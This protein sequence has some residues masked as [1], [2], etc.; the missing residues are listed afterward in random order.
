MNKTQAS[1][2]NRAF[3]AFE[4]RIAELK[5]KL[6]PLNIGGRIKCHPFLCALLVLLIAV[7]PVL[8]LARTQRT[9]KKTP[10]TMTKQAALDSLNT[11]LSDSIYP[12]EMSQ[13]KGVGKGEI[14]AW[15]NR[16]KLSRARRNG[17]RRE[18]KPVLQGERVEAVLLSGVKLK[19]S[20]KATSVLIVGFYPDLQQKLGTA[21]FII[22]ED[23]DGNGGDEPSGNSNSGNSNSGNSNS[24]NS[25]SGS[26]NSNHASNSNNTG[27]D[28]Q[29]RSNRC[30]ATQTPNCYECWSTVFTRPEGEDCPQ[31]ECT[32]DSNCTRTGCSG[33]GD[34][35][36]V[37]S[38]F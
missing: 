32:S 13:V 6:S 17:L 8:L 24:G 26:G 18:L 23:S 36:D 34:F 16:A 19:S 11:F 35:L 20:N 22:Y 21:G 25:N 33:G 30:R 27:N 10:S 31:S 1:W 9:P 15:L 38:A 2:S 4:V 28:V 29:C 5:R 12:A 3:R 37:L 7:P 14:S